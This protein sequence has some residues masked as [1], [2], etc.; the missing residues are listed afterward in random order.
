VRLETDRLVLREFVED[1][2]RALYAIES[3]EDVNRYQGYDAH[4]EEQSR[5]YVAKTIASAAETPRMLYEVAI[6][7][8]SDEQRLIGRGG[9]RRTTAEPRVGEMWVV[10]APS[11][12]KQGFV[13]EAARAM[14]SYAFAEL[15]MH[16]LYGDCDPRNTP[17][18]QLMERLG[19]RREAHFRE[20]VF[21]KGEW[22]DSAIYAVLASEWARDP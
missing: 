14:M 4:T 2:W 12:Q 17:S 16:R 5:A 21:I 13:L 20:N 15:A 9:I 6:A 10:L 7:K 19:M 22:C 11:E 1:D 18:A 8:R 3:R